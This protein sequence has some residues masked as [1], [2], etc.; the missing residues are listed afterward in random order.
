MVHAPYTAGSLV[1]AHMLGFPWWPA[2]VDDDPDFEQ[3]YWLNDFS[4]IPV[5][6]Y[7]ILFL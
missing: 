2:M 3:Y 5:L 6:I 7:K 1:W 4:D